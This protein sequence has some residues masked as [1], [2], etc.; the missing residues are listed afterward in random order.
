MRKSGEGRHTA[1]ASTWL[2]RLGLVDTRKN[3]VKL[4]TRREV[5]I[6]DKV[7]RTGAEYTRVKLSD[8]EIISQ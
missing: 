4:V 7:A 5:L 1:K 2:L 6:R 8:I 3:A